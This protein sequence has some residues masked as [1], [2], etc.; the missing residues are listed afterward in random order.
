MKKVEAVNDDFKAEI[1][2]DEAMQKDETPYF[3][4]KNINMLEFDSITTNPKYT[5][6]NQGV[7][8]LYYRECVYIMSE[9]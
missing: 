7:E 4:I 5:V 2:Y 8:E 9:I 1:Q 3:T 6:Y